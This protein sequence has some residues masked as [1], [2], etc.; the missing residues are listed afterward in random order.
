MVQKRG[1]RRW[2]VLE[3]QDSDHQP[4]I[5][6]IQEGNMV[7]QVWT[8]HTFKYYAGSKEPSDPLCQKGQSKETQNSL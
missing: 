6:L 5:V 3:A 7:T 8:R 2:V 4:C 1:S